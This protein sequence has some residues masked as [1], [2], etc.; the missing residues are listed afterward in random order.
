MYLVCRYIHKKEKK[1]AGTD[2]RTTN[3]DIRRTA[4]TIHTGVIP[5]R[6][7]NIN[8]SILDHSVLNIQLSKFHA[9]Y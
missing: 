4:T 8:S 2:T 6:D 5:A 7:R 3:M 1:Q 9:N